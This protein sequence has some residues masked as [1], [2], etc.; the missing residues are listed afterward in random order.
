MRK[1]GTKYYIEM[2]IEVDGS[3]TVEDAHDLTVKIRE[4]IMSKRDDIE[5][6]TIHVEPLGNVEKE[7]FGVRKGV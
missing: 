2:D 4:E 6:L 5:D 7:G 1:V 3:M